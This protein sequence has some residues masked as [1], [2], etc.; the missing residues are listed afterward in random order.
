MKVKFD[1]DTLYFNDAEVELNSRYTE[2][3]GRRF[4]YSRGEEFKK[5][6]KLGVLCQ[7]NHA[8]SEAQRRAG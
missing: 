4:T 8:L 5:A 3:I 7:E 1:K 2:V 6:W